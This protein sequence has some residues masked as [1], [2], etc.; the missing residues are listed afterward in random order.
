M[1][2]EILAKLHAGYFRITL[3][4]AAQ[5]LLWKIIILQPQPNSILVPKFFYFVFLS[6]AWSLSALVLAVLSALYSLRCVLRFDMI[7]EEFS[8]NVGVNYLFVPWISW[9]LLIE[10]APFVTTKTASFVTMWCIFAIPVLM[11]DVKIYGQWFT[12]GKRYLVAAANPTSLL[13]VIGNLVGSRAA[14][15]MGWNEVSVFLFSLGI[16]H[17]LVLFVTLYQRIPSGE[18]LPGMLRPSFFLFFA[19]PSVASLAW[20]S[21]SGSF[22]TVARMLFFL[23]FFMFASLACR[24][25]IFKTAMKRFHLSW[26]S[27]SFPV[28]MLALAATRYEQEVRS[29]FTRGIRI[30]LSAL[31]VLILLSLLL[32]S[33]FKSKSLL[34]DDDGS[35][36]L[37]AI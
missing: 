26:W 3:A 27:Y 6:L 5:V 15:K 33:G 18:S 14:A 8:S 22:D 24:P 32:F 34:R 16:A 37:T 31:S 29:G 4:L 2:T 36:E 13:T 28:T 23:S 12:A 35:P 30:L 20:Y 19:A 25:N 11:L 7:K 1:A 9:L 21:F 10:A 17:Y